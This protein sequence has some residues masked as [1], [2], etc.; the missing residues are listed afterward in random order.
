ME[1]MML[2]GTGLDAIHIICWKRTCLHF[3]L[4]PEILREAK[5]KGGRI[6]NLLENI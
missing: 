6:I 1:M 2:L 5:I 3:F 4:S